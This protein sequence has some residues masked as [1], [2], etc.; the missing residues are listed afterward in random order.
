[1]KRLSEIRCENCPEGFHSF[2]DQLDNADLQYINEQKIPKHYK[3]GEVIFTEGHKPLGIYCLREGKVKVYK[4]SFEGKEQITRVIFPGELL[5]LKALLSGKTYTVSSATLDD[6][7][8]CFIS[9]IDFFQLMLKYP[10]FT[11]AIMISLSQQ[12]EQAEFRMISLAH[13]PVR[14]RLAET[15]LFLNKTFH[16]TAPAYPQTYLNITRQDYANIIGTAPETV[17]RLLSEFKEA[18]L[19]KVKGRKIFLSDIPGLRII[20]NITE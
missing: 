6:C 2:F 16:P 10:E 7:D 1:M 15:L 3:K 20:A 17:I 4:I 18:N 19:I 14:E 11:R 9:K 12:L 8:V 5:G 13:K